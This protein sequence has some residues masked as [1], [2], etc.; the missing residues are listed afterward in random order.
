MGVNFDERLHAEFAAEREEV[1]QKPV[2]EGGYDKEKAVGVGGPRF[3][4]LPRVEDEI[5][6]KDWKCNAFSSVAKIFQRAVEE[7]LLGEDGKCG[8]PG[9]F[10]RFCQPGR[11]EGIADDA[12]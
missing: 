12:A 9:G 11:V 1:A 6:A 10:E 3:P 7:F 4:D 2:A 5:L 8:C